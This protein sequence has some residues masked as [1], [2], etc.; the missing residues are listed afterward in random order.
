MFC[1]TWISIFNWVNCCSTELVAHRS[2]HVSSA[3]VWHSFTLT[4][5]FKSQQSLFSINM[6]VLGFPLNTKVL[7]LHWCWM[8]Q[9]IQ[10]HWACVIDTDASVVVWG[11]QGYVGCNGCYIAGRDLQSWTGGWTAP[12]CTRAASEEY[13]MERERE[14]ERKFRSSIHSECTSGRQTGWFICLIIRSSKY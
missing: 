8:S 4:W 5:D 1:F 3:C 10:A 2:L 13:L 11:C 9:T 7:H 12:E 14:K 6:T